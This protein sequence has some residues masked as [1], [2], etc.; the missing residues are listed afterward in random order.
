MSKKIVLDAPN[1]GTLEKKFL[2]GAI[3]SGYV[4]TIGPYVSRFEDEFARYIGAD[5]AVSTQS[6]TSALYMALYELGIGKG[7]EVIVPALTFVASVNPIVN[8]GAIPVFAD[9]DPRTWNIDP[10]DAEG[11]ITRR[12]KAILPVHFYGNPCDMREIMKIAKRHKLYVVEDATESLGAD[13]EG[14][15][16]GMF[17]HMGCFSFN[18][19]KVITTG[20]GGMVVSRDK[21]RLGHI[22]FLVNQARDESRGYYHPEVGFNYRM[23]NVEAALGLAQMKR[24]DGFLEKK[25]SFNEI[26]RKELPFLTFQEEYKNAGSSWWFTCALFD[27]HV[28]VPR[29]QKRL[30][31]KN[32]PTRRIFTPVTEFPPYRKYRRSG[33]GNSYGIYEAGLCLPSSTLNSAK[34]IYH[35]C[36]VLRSF[37]GR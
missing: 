10:K 23:T 18:G 25:R 7:D 32:I 20:G 4:S 26:Y 34:D 22:K 1:L 16:T 6:G 33:Y 9:V 30:A 11:R 3:D 17:G 36:G 2:A 31:G 37:M 19:N 14:T 21:K 29:L 13:F 27:R 8:L 5:K 24:L 28:D 12:T 15:Y 35:V